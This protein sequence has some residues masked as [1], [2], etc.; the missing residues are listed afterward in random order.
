MTDERRFN[1]AYDVCSFINE[2]SRIK[3]EPYEL[4]MYTADLAAAM[5]DGKDAI[6]GFIHTLQEEVNNNCDPEIII[7]AK[8]FIALLEEEV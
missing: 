3:C 4:A 2:I 5:L 1:I 8:K 7:K 6:E